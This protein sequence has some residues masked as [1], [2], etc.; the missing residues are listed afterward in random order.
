MLPS[1]SR[2][3]F[4]FERIV[5]ANLRAENRGLNGIFVADALE[6]TEY[7][8]QAM[9]YQVD[10]RYREIVGHLPGET[11][12]QITVAGHRFLEGIHHSGPDQML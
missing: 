12:Q 8:N 6:A 2:G 11:L 1:D 4:L 3:G 7:P 10:F 9:L 5:I